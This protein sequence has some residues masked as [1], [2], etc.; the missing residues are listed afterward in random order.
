[1]FLYIVSGCLNRIAAMELDQDERNNMHPKNEK[2]DFVCFSTLMLF[3]FII[4]FYLSVCNLHSNTNPRQNS[5][6]ISL[7]ISF[8][9]PKTCHSI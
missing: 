7:E 3:P 1:M 9:W 2:R 4:M 6:K 8:H 5:R